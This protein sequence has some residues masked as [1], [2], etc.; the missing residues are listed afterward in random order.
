MGNTIPAHMRRSR[1]A[2]GRNQKK[3]SNKKQQKQ[4]HADCSDYPT[5]H[6]VLGDALTVIGT[7]N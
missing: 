5:D 3:N 1:P 2:V 7:H 4:R 6:R